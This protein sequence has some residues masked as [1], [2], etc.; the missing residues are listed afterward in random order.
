MPLPDLQQ[1][2]D[3]Q[4]ERDEHAAR[5]LVMALRNSGVALL[6][7]AMTAGAYWAKLHLHGPG[8]PTYWWMWGAA[9]GFVVAVCFAHALLA[10]RFGARRAAVF[11]KVVV[12]PA[13][14]GMLAGVWWYLQPK[15]G[16]V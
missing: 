13:L 11:L 1:L 14:A 9:A 8:G 4:T 12:A 10:W 7:I 5:P 2:A 3:P 16:G 6:G 15:N